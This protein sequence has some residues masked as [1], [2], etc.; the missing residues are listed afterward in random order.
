MSD[1]DFTGLN[2]EAETTGSTF[3]RFVLWAMLLVFAAASMITTF[4]FFANYA[5]GL[6]DIIHPDY[7][8]AIAGIMGVVLFDVAGLGWTVLRARNSDTSQ[9]FVIATVAALLTITLA[10]VTSGL[11]V[12]LASAFD[13]GLYL[14]DGSLSAAGQ[15]MQ[16]TGV[17]VMTTGFVANF[18]AIAA[19]INASK[20][21]ST[22]VQNTQLAAYLTGAKFA[23]DQARAQIV[24]QQT[25]QAIMQQL[26]QVA[27]TAGAKNR[28]AYLDR[29]GLVID[30]QPDR[31]TPAVASADSDDKP[32]GQPKRE[33][34]FGFPGGQPTENS[35][36]LLAMAENQ[37]GRARPANGTGPM[38]AGDTVM[39]QAPA[40][41]VKTLM[42]D[43]N[44]KLFFET[45]VDEHGEAWSK[46]L[47][48]SSDP[49]HAWQ[50]VQQSGVMIPRRMDYDKFAA[51]HQTAVNFTTR[52]E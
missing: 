22:A 10:L 42:F 50:Q 46:V 26:P 20:E 51:L 5:P 36:D 43:K 18:A 1:Y 44:Q 25:L 7:G 41:A 32:T 34:P 29:T 39:G 12:I 13:V 31:P 21:I 33:R 23:A 27:R 35:V 6:G 17:I 48:L 2:F 14:T 38:R 9:Q 3:G 40:D 15:N 30:Q 52:A 11:Q 8:W 19:Y 24:T 16:L 37:A 45:W 47:G 49:R 28:D 4:G